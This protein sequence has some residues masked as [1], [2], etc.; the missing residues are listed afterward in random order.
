MAFPGFVVGAVCLAILGCEPAS[1]PV[2][3]TSDQTQPPSVAGGPRDGFGQRLGTD[4][5]SQPGRSGEQPRAERPTIVAFGDSLTAGLGVS[6]EEAFP[7]QLQRRLDAADYQFRVIN[8]GVSG[9]T[10][11]GGVR[12]IDWVLS[13]RPRIVILELGA[14]DGL[15]GIDLSQT[16]ANLEQIITRLQA[17]GVTVVLAGMKL[18]PNYGPEYTARFAALYPDLARRYRLVSIPFFLEGVA[19]KTALNQADGIHPTA[20]GYRVIVDHLMPVLEPLL[21]RGA[22]SRS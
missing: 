1:E 3:S 9:D 11:A 5:T 2:S 20:E 17:A 6:P 13:S 4:V 22:S 7:A 18:P 21:G 12:R 19:A 8:A 15:R 14:N 10:T 16:R